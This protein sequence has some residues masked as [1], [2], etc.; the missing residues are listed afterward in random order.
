MPSR[1]A[2]LPR[3][4][5]AATGVDSRAVAAMFDDLEARDVECHSLMVVRHG[6]VVAEG[7]WAPYSADRPHL[8]YS[9]T[10]SFTSVAVGLAVADGLLALDD[11]V[12][13]VLPDHVPHDV[14]DQGRRLTV[15]HLLSMTTGHA[16]DTL[17]DAWGLEPGDLVKGFLR[18]P[19]AAP[20]GTRHVYDNATTFVLAR[21]VERVTGRGLPELLDERL[22]RP[23][24]IEHAEWDRVG[25]GAAFGF[26]G[27]HLTT[28]ALAAFGELL[29]RGGRWGDQQLVPREWVELA[30]RQHV[31]T[32]H[33]EGSV[34]GADAWCGYG[35]Q[36]WMSRHGY[37]AHGAYG[38]RCVVVPSHDLVVAVTGATEPQDVL[39]AIWEHLL[40]GLD[41]PTSAR[42]DEALADRM[43]RLSLPTV[44]GSAPAGR[45]VTARVVAPDADSPLA[46]GTSVVVHPTGDGW[47]VRLGPSIEVAVG[48]AA[49][50]ESTPLGRPVV[51][52]GAWQGDTFVADLVVVTTPHRV[53]LVVDAGS[54]TAVATWSTPPLTTPDLALHLRSPLM[55]RPRHA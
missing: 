10:K 13:D 16:T 52:S 41:G 29:L 4:T 15:H 7:W 1:R 53:R 6:H 44:P 38:Q 33:V 50:R 34:E 18:V 19:F 20:E 2:L 14:P 23:M 37:R 22:F 51:A 42:D 24:G 54:G 46:D 26:H 48:H 47:V 35:Y 25:S 40:P 28:E 8:L 36:F 39:D 3:S 43:R 45:A 9:A 11:R 32:A 5:P 12:V 27:L 49:W 55:T 31:P 30:T 17:E 21:M